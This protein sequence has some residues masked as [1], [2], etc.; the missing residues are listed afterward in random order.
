SFRWFGSGVTASYSGSGNPFPVSYTVLAYTSADATINYDAMNP[1]QTTYGNDVFLGATSNIVSAG[2]YLTSYITSANDSLV[3]RYA[4]AV[5]ID[6]PYASFSGLGSIPIGTWWGVS[7]ISS[8]SILKTDDD[9]PNSPQDF[10]SGHVTLIPE[11]AAAGLAIFGVAA[12]FLRRR[13]MRG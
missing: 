4:Y 8:S 5:L 7:A 12:M 3:G 6:L 10:N 11:P 9:P 13:K 2:Y 1:F